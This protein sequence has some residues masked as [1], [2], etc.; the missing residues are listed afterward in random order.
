V[1]FLT[2]LVDYKSIFN[3]TIN[4]PTG[5]FKYK[6]EMYEHFNTKPV[7]FTAMKIH[8]VVFW[9]VVLRS[10]V[11]GYQPGDGGSKVL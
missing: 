9:F 6:N 3:P 11:A 2:H 4:T 10:D 5:T 7:V 1:N 8:V